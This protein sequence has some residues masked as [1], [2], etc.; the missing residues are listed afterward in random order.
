M[1]IKFRDGVSMVS[2]EEIRRRLEAKR[3]GEKFKEEKKPAHKVERHVPRVEKPVQGGKVCPSCKTD[4]PQ[5]AKFCVGC[6][7]ALKEPSAAETSRMESITELSGN[8]PTEPGTIAQSEDFKTCPDCNHK[9][10][11]QAKFCVV[12][13][14]KFEE[15][16][17]KEVADKKAPVALEEPGEPEEI[18]EEVLPTK[19]PETVP[20]EKVPE[21]EEPP[22][23][24]VAERSEDVKVDPVERIK[25][26]KEL[27]DIGAIT[28]EEFDKIKNKYLDEI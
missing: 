8:V 9:N 24:E 5:N 20:E 22:K 12:C 15:E 2:N 14:H 17:P 18:A 25:E 23:T 6:G 27:L 26:A 16:A 10:P 13:G 11:Q 3:R 19:E 4:N 1:I 21:T 7:E 28:Q